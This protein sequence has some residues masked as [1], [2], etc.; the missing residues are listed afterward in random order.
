MIHFREPREPKDPPLIENFLKRMKDRKSSLKMSFED[1][2]REKDI[3]ESKKKLESEKFE[4][5]LLGK[6]R[7]IYREK[8]LKNKRKIVGKNY[9]RRHY[10]TR[11]S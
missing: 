4:D 11:S 9:A 6:A 8:R 7:E 1:R 2:Y 5:K 3:F 10:N